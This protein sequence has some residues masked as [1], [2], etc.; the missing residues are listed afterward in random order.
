MYVIFD[1]ADALRLSLCLS[2]GVE[3]CADPYSSHVPGMKHIV[4]MTHSML[5][6]KGG[7]TPVSG[8]LELAGRF[9]LASLERAGR[10]N[11]GISTHATQYARTVT[12][13]PHPWLQLAVSA[14]DGSI[15]LYS[16]Q[17]PQGNGQAG[18]EAAGELR[19]PLVASVCFAESIAVRISKRSNSAQSR[20]TAEV[21]AATAVGAHVGL[22][23]CSRFLAAC[24]GGM[25]ALFLAVGCRA[26]KAIGYVIW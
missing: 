10:A 7:S 14:P 20:S 6:Q 13:L 12:L 2:Q 18:S 9:P 17:R 19:T 3:Y 8:Q 24:R 21:T 1:V 26:I 16:L 23:G 4:Q 15:D 25:R 11:G 22:S 5:M